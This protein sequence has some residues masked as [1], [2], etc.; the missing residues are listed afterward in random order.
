MNVKPFD[1]DVALS[2]AGEDREYVSKVA[3]ELK[4]MGVRIF[5]DS[6][7]TVNL[8]G[9]D[10]YSHFDE[11]YRKRAQFCLMFLSQ[12]YASKV[13]TNHERRAAQSRA[14][15][16]NREYI[17]PVRLDNAEVPGI[18]PTVAYIDAVSWGP[19]EIAKAVLQKMQSART[20]SEISG[21]EVIEGVWLNKENNTHVYVTS[22]SGKLYAPYCYCGDEE[23]TAFYYNWER[24]RNYFFAQF[25]WVTRGVQ[26]YE[27]LR[28]ISP[29]VLEGSWWYADGKESGS[30][31]KNLESLLGGVKMRWERIEGEVPDWVLKFVTELRKGAF[32]A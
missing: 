29:D 20:A 31:E 10:L 7:E 13:W 23:L 4:R 16:E 32:W 27:F 9:K 21:L 11:I 30:R 26:G 19:H 5:Y 12:H 15:Q 1:Y 2:F 14:I 28:L 18:T 3:E 24:E 22:L 25:R 17:L 6:F 8:W